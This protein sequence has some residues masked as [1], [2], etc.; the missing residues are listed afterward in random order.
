MKTNGICSHTNT[1]TNIDGVLQ[2]CNTQHLVMVAVTTT[3]PTTA[4]WRTA[5]SNR[6]GRE[7]NRGAVGRG[8]N[9]TYT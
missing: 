8:P 9:K 4:P 6:E 7:L 2:P 5:G 1:N 3:T